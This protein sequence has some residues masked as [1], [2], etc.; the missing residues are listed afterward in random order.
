MSE[1]AQEAPASTNEAITN[2]R[3]ALDSIAR[4]DLSAE[5]TLTERPPNPNTPVPSYAI[6]EEAKAEPAPEKT[7]PKVES[8]PEVEEPSTEEPVAAE[9]EEPQPTDEKSKIRWKELKQAEKDLKSAQKELAELKKRGEEFES[10]S[11]EV[12]T[13][14]A[15]I[16]EIKAEREALDGELYISRV[17]SSKEYKQ[18][19][20][21]PLNKL[22]DDVD[23]YA[24]RNNVDGSDI[25]DALEADINGNPKALEELLADWSE[26]DKTKIYTLADNMLAIHNRKQEIEQNSKEAFELSQKRELAE[27]EQAYKQFIAQRETAINTVIPKIGEKVFNLLPEDK[28]PDVAKLQQEIMNYD[29]WPEDLKVYGIAGAA[30]LP[31]LVDRITSLQSELETTRKENIKLRGGAA[32][33]AGGSSPRTPQ[34]TNKPIDYTKVDTE[35]FVKNMVSRMVA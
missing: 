8:T 15:Q 7:E 28:R 18:Y 20:T 21:E 16:E 32:P 35:D 17:Q 3:G 2:L 10:T 30:I 13:L 4:N 29:E 26:R 25:V 14:K 33:A 24:K 5:S 34:D 6:K 11:K 12:D 9:S 27:R 1:Q 31:D 22:F 23:F 19:V